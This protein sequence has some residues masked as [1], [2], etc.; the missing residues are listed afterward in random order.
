M[1]ASSVTNKLLIRE[2][3]LERIRHSIEPEKAAMTCFNSTAAKLKLRWLHFGV[4]SLL[5]TAPL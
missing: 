5:R 1:T 2:R 3:L 4:S